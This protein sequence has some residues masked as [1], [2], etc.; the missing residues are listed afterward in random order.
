MNT[1]N[2]GEE[3]KVAVQNQQILSMTEQSGLIV[4][5]QN[6][7][8]FI[9]PPGR[10]KKGE[11]WKQRFYHIITPEFQRCGEMYRYDLT[12]YS[13]AIGEPLSITWV[14]YLYGDAPSKD[15]LILNGS[16]NVLYPRQTTLNA[17]Q[18]IGSNGRLYLKFGPISQ[19]YNSFVLDY[20]SGSTGEV[21]NHSPNG[22][23]VILKES[24]TEI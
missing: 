6:L 4:R 10:Y 1:G 17:Y 14:G 9:H 22:Y 11:E 13:Y 5:R 7:V 23:E 12:G 21:I 19:Y 2:K 24:D 18:Y 20:Q 16:V 8:Q 3:T 15:Q